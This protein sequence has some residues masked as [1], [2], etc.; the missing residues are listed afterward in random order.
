MVVVA[1]VITNTDI[2]HHNVCI[3]YSLAS[4]GAD[5]STTALKHA[6]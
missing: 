4:Y 3:V 6:G 5:L 2:L 1:A